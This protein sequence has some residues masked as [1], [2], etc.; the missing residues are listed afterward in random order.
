MNVGPNWGQH[1][2]R[3]QALSPHVTFDPQR[4]NGGPGIFSH[5]ISGTITSQSDSCIKYTRPSV[6]YRE[7]KV[8]GHTPCSPVP[9]SSL[10]VRNI[11]FDLRP[12]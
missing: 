6:L 4:K 9:R 1:N 8:K 12:Q 7:S 3:T 11:K 5:V 2:P 10:S